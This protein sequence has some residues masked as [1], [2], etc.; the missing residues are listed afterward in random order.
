L[1]LLLV[2]LFQVFQCLRIIE[3]LHVCQP[4]LFSFDFP[5]ST[6]ITE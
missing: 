2:L 3:P 4:P 6:I 5:V 1:L